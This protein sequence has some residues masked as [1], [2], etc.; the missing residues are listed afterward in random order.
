MLSEFWNE[1]HSWLHTEELGAR[2]VQWL[3]WPDAI[4]AGVMLGF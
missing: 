4:I 1:S 2:W 3:S